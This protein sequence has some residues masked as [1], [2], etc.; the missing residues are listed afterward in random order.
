MV[1]VTK[2]FCLVENVENISLSMYVEC[3]CEIFRS[4]VFLQ[5]SEYRR[6]SHR[7][8]YFCCILAR[9]ETNLKQVKRSHN[10]EWIVLDRVCHVFVEQLD[11]I[12]YHNP[13]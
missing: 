7:Y 3:N 10:P 11:G 4:V 9:K 5:S 13:M 12:N 2:A 1:S 8:N 6:R